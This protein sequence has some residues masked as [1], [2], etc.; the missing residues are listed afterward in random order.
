MYK[1]NNLFCKNNIYILKI[2]LK[3]VWKIM[4]CEVKNINYLEW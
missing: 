1:E 3:I 4:Q 2:V